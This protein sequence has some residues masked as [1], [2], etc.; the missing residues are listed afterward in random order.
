MHHWSPLETDDRYRRPS[1]CFTS[2]YEM[3]TP[4]QEVSVFWQAVDRVVSPRCAGV[5]TKLEQ[6]LCFQYRLRH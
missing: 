1:A 6:T 5:T 2:L 4:F 3:H